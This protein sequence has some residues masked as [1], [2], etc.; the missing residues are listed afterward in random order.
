MDTNSGDIE[1]V[2]A[3]NL[4]DAISTLNG[5][6]STMYNGFPQNIWDAANNTQNDAQ[7]RINLA[8][9]FD[10]DSN[11]NPL[12]FGGELTTWP[13]AAETDNAGN[14]ILVNNNPV[15]AP[16]PKSMKDAFNQLHTWINANEIHQSD[17]RA[18]RW[19]D[20]NLLQANKAYNIQ[21]RGTHGEVTAPQS[22]MYGSNMHNQMK[23]DDSNRR[24]L[25]AKFAFINPSNSGG[26]GQN[27]QQLPVCDANFP[28]DQQPNCIVRG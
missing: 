25:D 23:F 8:F 4:N 10:K 17:T 21:L 28:A 5:N 14:L 19:A 3:S 7:R 22:Y 27:G 20:Q 26:D 2:P 1:M 24:M 13:A 16:R 6:D 9:G 18:R 12:E 11:N 15:A